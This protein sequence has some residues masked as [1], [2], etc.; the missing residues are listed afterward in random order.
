MRHVNNN[1]LIYLT[2]FSFL[3]SQNQEKRELN[4]F[5]MLSPALCVCVWAQSDAFLLTYLTI[6]PKNLMDVFD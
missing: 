6:S 3:R 1:P 4:A 2:S 5:E